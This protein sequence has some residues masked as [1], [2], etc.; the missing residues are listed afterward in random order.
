MSLCV[1]TVPTGMARSVPHA[2][3]IE[4]CQRCA[5]SPFRNILL[6]WTAQ[7]ASTLPRL[8]DGNIANFQGFLLVKVEA[9]LEF[10][11]GRHAEDH[12]L[13]LLVLLKLSFQMI[14]VEIV[15]GRRRGV[16]PQAMRRPDGEMHGALV[17]AM[18]KKD[19]STRMTGFQHEFPGWRRVVHAV[20]EA[21][22]EIARRHRTSSF[23]VPSS[24]DSCRH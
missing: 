8:A 14:I 16:L 10:D 21:K 18:H 1:R 7:L 20:A 11:S 12:R 24:L 17:F 22:R 9:H 19:R 5:T 2:A 6:R 13:V 15:A 4:V 23:L 3:S